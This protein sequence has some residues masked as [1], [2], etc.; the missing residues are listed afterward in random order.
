MSLSKQILLFGDRTNPFDE[1]IRKLAERKD[2]PYLLAFFERCNFAIRAEIGKLP[3]RLR[4]EFPRFSS[5]LDLLARHRKTHDNPA[6]EGALTCFH[7][8]ATFIA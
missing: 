5:I 2:N 7:Q 8:I 3:S 4:A 6:I 1:G